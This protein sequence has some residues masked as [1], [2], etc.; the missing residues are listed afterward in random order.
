MFPYVT[1]DQFA[2]AFERFERTKLKVVGHFEVV[3]DVTEAL[4]QDFLL[5]HDDALQDFFF[6]A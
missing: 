3:P 2:A 5:E 4:I 1:D 6:R